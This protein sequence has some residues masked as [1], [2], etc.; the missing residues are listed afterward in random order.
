MMQGARPGDY[1]ASTIQ[2]SPEVGDA[3]QEGVINDQDFEML[4]KELG[5]GGLLKVLAFLKKIFP[6]M[7]SGKDLIGELRP[8][9]NDRPSELDLETMQKM[10]RDKLM[11]GQ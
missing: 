3:N 8:A 6:G 4:N 11:G 5:A 2:A 10:A 1:D 9:R 7:I